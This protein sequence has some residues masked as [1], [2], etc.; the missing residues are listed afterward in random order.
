MW[1][2]LYRHRL[3]FILDHNYFVKVIV[4]FELR[5]LCSTLAGKAVLRN[6]SHLL[7]PDFKNMAAAKPVGS[8][9]VCAIA[10]DA[11]ED[12]DWSKPVYGTEHSVQNMRQ[13]SVFQNICSAY[14]AIPT[15][16]LTYPVLKSKEVVDDLS[17][18]LAQSQ[19]DLGLQLH[20]WVTP[21]FEGN[22]EESMSERNSFAANL[23]LDLENRKIDRLIAEFFQCFCIEPKVYR[24]GRY[25]LSNNTLSL[26]EA[27]G[28]LV[29]TSVAP[30]TNFS[31]SS[32]PDYQD[33]GFQPFWF[34]ENR[35]LLEIP[36]CRDIVGVFSKIAPTLYRLGASRLGKQLRLHTFL[37]LSRI[38]ERITLSPE[39]ND[40]S[41]LKR[42]A[43]SLIRKNG[44]LFVLSFHSSSLVKGLN[45]YVSTTRESRHFYDR[46]SGIM[47]YLATE[48]DVQ[49]VK[50][51]DLPNHF[52]RPSAQVHQQKHSQVD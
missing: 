4:S 29:D 9:P 22:A 48:L 3:S 52:R 16:L 12:F 13:L 5:G 35:H 18:L 33:F 19:C 10:V 8:R 26:L 30:Y 41:A 50:L 38:A 46:L 6:K 42:L 36:L 20:P 47:Y 21:P 37:S 24:A 44:N 31:D 32:G 27:R 40:L 1:S 28:I 23:P 7:M 34:G 39:G 45:P 15:Y 43:N 25:G 14:G 49:F 11:E 51:A 2:E 17:A